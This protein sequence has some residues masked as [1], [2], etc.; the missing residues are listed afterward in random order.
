MAPAGQASSIH[1]DGQQ[2]NRWVYLVDGVQLTTTATL[3]GRCDSTLKL[4]NKSS[5]FFAFSVKGT[6]SCFI[7][8]SSRFLS[9]WC[10]VCHTL[11]QRQQMCVRIGS[12]RVWS[13]SAHLSSARVNH[14][15]KWVPN[16]PQLVGRLSLTGSPWM[17]EH[18]RYFNTWGHFLLT[19]FLSLQL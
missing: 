7:A 9:I 14:R 12:S 3:T 6:K 11:T 4:V 13:A 19:Q 15:P 18:G 5:S 16:R 10:R 2:L 8:A 1:R 17:G